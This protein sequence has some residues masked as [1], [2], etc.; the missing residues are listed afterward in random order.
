MLRSQG[1]GQRVPR[2]FSFFVALLHLYV[3]KPILKLMR[4]KMKT[5]LTFLIIIC[6][7]GAIVQF[8][9][10][11]KNELSAPENLVSEKTYNIELGD[12]FSKFK[13]ETYSDAEGFSS[14][15]IKKNF[16]HIEKLKLTGFEHDINFYKERS[17]DIDGNKLLLLFGDVGVH[18]QNIQIVKVIDG[19][20]KTVKIEENK[21]LLDNTVSDVPNF[22]VIDDMK[23]LTI[24]LRDYDKDPTM[25]SKRNFYKWKNGRFVFDRAEDFS[26]N[27]E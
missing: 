7:I 27:E 13:I 11:C 17:A 24:D 16:A 9:L 23:T 8:I 4:E 14:Y 19:K 10:I 5:I 6:S 15:I 12:K 21:N 22:A 18:A 1:L 25:F 20:I 2:L 26:Y 3:R